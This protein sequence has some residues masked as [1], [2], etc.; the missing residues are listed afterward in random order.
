MFLLM[1]PDEILL[2]GGVAY[3]V[4]DKK[5]PKKTGLMSHERSEVTRKLKHIGCI[6]RETQDLKCILVHIGAAFQPRLWCSYGDQL[7][8]LSSCHQL[9][10]AL[11]ALE[12]RASSCHQHCHLQRKQQNTYFI[13]KNVCIKMMYIP[14]K[15]FFLVKL[16][17]AFVWSCWSCRDFLEAFMSSQEFLQIFRVQ[18]VKTSRRH[19]GLVWQW[20]TGEKKR[21]MHDWMYFLI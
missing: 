13:K 19:P 10:M 21:T 16:W 11:V 15:L 8:H 6:F 5:E 14:W 3:E 17:C 2:T 12:H 1:D 7:G 4:A 18:P 9:D 20:K